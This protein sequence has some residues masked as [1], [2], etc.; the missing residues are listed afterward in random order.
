MKKELY[1]HFIYLNS[2]FK[3]TEFKI[4]ENNNLEINELSILGKTQQSINLT[5]SSIGVKIFSPQN[6]YSVVIP[7]MLLGSLVASLSQI[8]LTSHIDYLLS[9]LS[10]TLVATS[11]ILLLSNSVKKKFFCLY[12]LSS[13]K[14]IYKIAINPQLSNV[15]E[16]EDFT[17]VIDL[18]LSNNYLD[19]S[20]T[21]NF[22]LNGEKEDQYSNLMYN[23]ECLYNSGIVD[24]NTFN[25]IEININQKLYP[26]DNYE[27]QPMADVIYLHNC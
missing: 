17:D 11:S 13:G 23:L 3:T 10:I 8:F 19:D 2:F 24:D 4:S 9:I 14:A 25:R 12:N 20:F 26:S 16:V 15:N 21:N 27:K 22:D 18:K 6:K 1:T 7:F 5:D